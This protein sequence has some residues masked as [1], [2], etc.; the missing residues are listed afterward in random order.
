LETFVTYLPA[1]ACGAM[2]LL[3]CIPMMRNMHKGHGESAGTASRQEIA[4]LREEVARL[5]AER[6][7]EDASE[8]VDG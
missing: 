5:K 3:V 6:A 2:L 4:E 8:T 1:I 7:L